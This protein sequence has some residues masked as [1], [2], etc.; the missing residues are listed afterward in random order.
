VVGLLN[1]YLSR[2]TDII[3]DEDGLVDKFEGDAIMAFWGAPLPQ[4]DQALRAC[5]ATVWCSGSLAQ[6]P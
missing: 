6:V 5:R 4:E 1:D 3:L 2:M